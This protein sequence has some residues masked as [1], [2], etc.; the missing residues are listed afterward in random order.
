MARKALRGALRV[1]A[2]RDVALLA[3]VAAC[4]AV[5]VF[6]PL[7]PAA[8]KCPPP[9]DPPIQAPFSAFYY[10][11]DLGPV[12]Q[13]PSLLA[14]AVTFL[15]GDPDTLLIARPDPE[16]WDI[17]SIGVQRDATG[18][19]VGFSGTPAFFASTGYGNGDMDYDP[20]GILF[21]GC[22]AT[23]ELR[24]IKPGSAAAD[25]VIDMAPFGVADAVSGLGFVPEGFPGAGQFKVVSWDGGEW[26]TVG[27]AADGLG[28]FDVTHA[29]L[30]TQIQGGPAGL[31][32][33]PSGYPLFPGQGGLLV[34]EY[35]AGEIAAYELDADGDPLPETRRSFIT[36]LDGG[37]A[38]AVF[39]P[40]TGDFVF[41]TYGNPRVLV[42]R[43][44]T[45]SP[46]KTWRHGGRSL[47]VPDTEP[48]GAAD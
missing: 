47:G 28:T 9:E 43:R 35:S 15:A 5:C 33:V 4:I 29:T 45:P 12:P 18:H 40:V 14:G 22:C 44:V 42:V 13:P 3:G 17:Y 19:I 32:Y 11:T 48:G 46:L 7:C 27:L 20:S 37:P 41:S 26:Y 6:S 23:N 1:V 16:T 36:G 38:G 10:A 34:S 21:L 39:D 2:T 31:V 30:E 8:P 24:Q 25:K